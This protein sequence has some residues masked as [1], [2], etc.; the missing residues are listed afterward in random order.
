MDMRK[1]TPEMNSFP[2][3]V[4][5]FIGNI[6]NLRCSFCGPRQE[7]WS[8]GKEWVMLDEVDKDIDGELLN[9]ISPVFHEADWLLLSGGGEPF[10]TKAFWDFVE[11]KRYSNGLKFNTNGTMFS[12]KNIARLLQYPKKNACK[13]QS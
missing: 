8:L 10:V 3:V 2:E 7:A 12:E 11:G 13:H 9:L 4:Q 1:R 5:I 6:C